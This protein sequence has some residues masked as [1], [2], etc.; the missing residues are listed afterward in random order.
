M[1]H[2]GTSSLTQLLLDFEIGKRNNDVSY[3]LHEM[4]KGYWD[5]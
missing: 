4:V 3:R 5:C 1:I 2:N